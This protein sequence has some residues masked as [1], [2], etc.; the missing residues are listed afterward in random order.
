MYLPSTL[1]HIIFAKRKTMA[2]MFNR[3]CPTNFD[4]PLL[5]ASNGPRKS[6]LTNICHKI[7]KTQ[8]SVAEEGY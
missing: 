6:Q 8:T 5:T 2:H 4:I 1:F 3:V 7:A